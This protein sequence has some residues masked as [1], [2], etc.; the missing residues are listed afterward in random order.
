MIAKVL[1]LEKKEYIEIIKKQQEICKN[2]TIA[3]NLNNIFK[4]F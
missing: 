1:M 3:H 4:Y 2:F